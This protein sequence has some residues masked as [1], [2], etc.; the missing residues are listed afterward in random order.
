[1]TPGGYLFRLFRTDFSQ[2]SAVIEK[3]MNSEIILEP[4]G[5]R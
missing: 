3:P 5:E 4:T 1:M 2:E